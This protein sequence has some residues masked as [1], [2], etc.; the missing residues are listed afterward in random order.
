MENKP[1][2]PQREGRQLEFKRE[3]KNY[4]HLIRTVV[5]FSN[6]IGGTIIIGV[7]D[8]SQEVVGLGSDEIER[9]MEDIPKAIYDAVAPYCIP[10]LRTRTI[11][12]RVLVEVEVFPG[13]RKPYYVKQEGVPKGVYYRVGPH[14]RRARDELVEDLVR[15]SRG[16]SY[17]EQ[18]LPNLAV[19]DLDQTALA[20]F[21]KIKSIDSSLLRADRVISVDPLSKQELPT[22]AGTVFF[23]PN[24]GGTVKGCEA[25]FS[26]FK[27]SNMKQIVRTIDISAPLPNTVVQLLNLIEPNLILETTRNGPRLLASKHQIPLLA[28]R[29]ALVNA[30]IH[31]HYAIKA[32]IKVA[33]FK[34]RLEIFS[35]GNF[36]GPIDTS[37]L[38]NGISYYRNPT[39]AHLA[40][41][42]G[43]I[44]RRGLGFYLMLEACRD[45]GNPRPEVIEGGD[46]V[47][48]IL[49]RDVDE[50]G[51]DLDLPQ[52]LSQLEQL[53]QSRT[54]LTTSMVAT[55]LGV[56]E[57]TAR[58]RLHELSELGLIKAEGKGRATRYRWI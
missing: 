51:K 4:E 50:K 41:K 5:A 13:Q 40:R 45:N 19:T 57:S 46:Y 56:S 52:H 49:S 33:L 22:V 10:R 32:P 47:K 16:E 2:I 20:S 43:L 8:G 27:G 14:N 30:M 11:D 1:I 36:P 7:N 39:L 42:A 31:R 53:R 24:P 35:P 38:G 54:E 6:D 25:L 37:E 48:V 12:N 15:T 55:A 29:E 21:Y 17:D 23:H 58:N 26:E 18:L 3:L 44:E 34:D 28:I 9:L